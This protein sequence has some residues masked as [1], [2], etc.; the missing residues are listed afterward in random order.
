MNESTTHAGVAAKLDILG[1]RARGVGHITNRCVKVNVR[2]VCAANLVAVAY[3]GLKLR[4]VRG[5]NRNK[6]T[7]LNGGV[8]S[9]RQTHLIAAACAAHTIRVASN[10]KGLWL[11]IRTGWH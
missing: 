10:V 7:R 6:A 11:G 1:G 2:A 3:Q 8:A 4:N 9:N 5:I